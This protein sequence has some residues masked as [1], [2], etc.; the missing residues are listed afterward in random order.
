MVYTFE[1]IKHANIRYREAVLRI[2]CCELYT[3]LH[4]ISVFSDISV[5]SLGGS[6]FLS[7]DCRELSPE[8][9]SYL[10]GHSSLAFMAE[11]RNNLLRPLDVVRKGFLPEDLPEVLKYKGKTSV[12]FTRMMINTALALTPFPRDMENLLFFDP[13][14]GKGTSCFCALCSGLNAVGV[15]CDRNAVGEAVRYF[16]S[17]LKFH[18]L[19]HS[20]SSRSETFRTHSVMVTDFVFSD[21]K[22]HYLAGLTKRLSLCP[23]DTMESPVLFR[24]E[25]AHLIVADLPYGI[26]HAPY[27]SGRPSSLLS[28]LQKA[29]PVWKQA[30]APGAAV[31]VSFNTLT[32]P[33][34]DVRSTMLSFG[35]VPVD[36]RCFLDLKHEVEHA[37]VRD[38]IFAL[39]P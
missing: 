32:L 23:A 33:S 24:R 37:V 7:F 29:I 34:S 30:L 12:P 8:E 10:S 15:D 16:S 25:K 39:S 17:Y 31:A 26:Q 11:R 22:E 9:I 19:K 35:L 38:V 28:F 13:V 18:K 2:A 4:Q 14:C 21:T 6:A 20:M 1:L 5:E 36:D 3:M 27:S